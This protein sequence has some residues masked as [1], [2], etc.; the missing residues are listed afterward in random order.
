[1]TI[2][3]LYFFLY[4]Q[5]TAYDI[6]QLLEFR[7]VLFRSPV[8]VDDGAARHLTGAA[9][10]PVGLPSTSGGLVRLDDAAVSLVVVYCY[11]IGRASC[12]KECTDLWWRW[13]EYTCSRCCKDIVSGW[14]IM[15]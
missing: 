14:L 2:S 5:K 11:Q 8:P 13:C 6:G 7:R 10:P 1:M 3:Y 9:L 4:K 12:R 15:T